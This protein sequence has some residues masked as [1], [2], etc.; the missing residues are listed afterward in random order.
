MLKEKYHISADDYSVS[1]I[2]D[3]TKQRELWKLKYYPH[4]IIQWAIM[5]QIEGIFM[6]T[7]T[8][9]TCASIK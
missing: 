7:F 9:F 8:N 3:K 1:I 5:L 6:N 2:W 4:R